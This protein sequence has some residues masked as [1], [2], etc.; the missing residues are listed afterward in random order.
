MASNETPAEGTES[1]SPGREPLTPAKRKRLQKL[2][3]HGSKQLA[4]ENHD[5]ATELFAECVMGDPSNVIY[6]QNYVGNLQRKYNNNRTGKAFAQFK[7]RGAR[8]AVKKALAR[9]EWDEVIRHGLKVL[10]VNPWDIPALTAMATASEHSGDDEVELYYLKCALEA[11]PKDPHV[12][13]QCA[14]A[15]A[16]R[17]EFDQA[18]ACWHRVEQARPD[19]EEAQR[20]IA[21]LA[22]E[23][24]IVRGGYDEGDEARRLAGERGGQ[25][26]EAQRIL[27]REERLQARINRDP[28][29]LANYFELAQLHIDSERYQDAEEVFARAL[30]VSDGDPDVRERWEDAQL[31]RL[32]QLMIRAEDEPTRKRFRKQLI[33][34]ELVVYKNRCDRYPNNL[35]FKYDLGYRYQLNEQYNEAIKEYQQARNDPRRRALCMLRLGQCFEQIEQYRLAMSHYESAIEEI[36]DREAEHKKDALYRAARLSMNLNDLDAAERHLTNLAGLDF[37]YKDVSDLL[38]KIAELRKNA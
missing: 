9:G 5:Y 19:N 36:P 18:I 3:E 14:Q 31:R 21:R 27:S 8:S 25:A 20:E 26:Q 17:R 37:S 38:G 32:R 35:S 28:E 24:T 10:T 22:V 29:E 34:K 6:V 15:L 12:N 23:K 11:S 33:E 16:A 2:F 13:R 4:Q 1:Q 30:E 7:E